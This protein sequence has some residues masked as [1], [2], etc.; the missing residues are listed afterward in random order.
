MTN[1]TYPRG[2]TAPLA[3]G[4]KKSSLDGL[5]ILHVLDHSLPIH[6]GYSFRSAAL[7]REQRRRGWQTFHLTTTK[8]TESGPSPE[9]VDEFQFER[10]PE[11]PKLI[12]KIPAVHET[13]IICSVAQRITQIAHEIRP[14]ILHAHSPALN[15][16]ACLKAARHLRLPV[17]YEIRGFWEDAAVSHGT[18]REGGLR[19][20]ATHALESHVLKKCNAIATICDGLRSDL[21]ARG[22]PL[23]LITVIPN[24]V[25]IDEFPFKDE[26]E[27]QIKTALDLQG[28]QTIGFVGSFYE[29]EGLDL[30]LSAVAQV[31]TRDPNLILLLVGGGP[32]ETALKAQASRLGI[33][34]SVRFV[35]RV[36]HN[37]IQQYYRAIDINVYPRHPMRLTHTVTPLKPLEAMAQGCIVLASDVGGHRELIHHNDTGYLFRAGDVEACERAIIGAFR[38]RA[39][40]QRIRIHA[41][42]YVERERT[43]ASS[44]AGYEHLYRVALATPRKH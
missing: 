29:Y 12:R 31:L 19:Y 27:E 33:E 37:L 39:D 7:F 21:V 25:D 20:R 40:W 43:W 9:L 38:N 16:L 32:A 42:R 36:P 1:L 5:R 26:P 14:D 4:R 15:A 18:A 41:R 24:G 28:R 10:T 23:D 35:G 8:H 13:A 2:A 44:A 11:L 6:S 17:V 34:S 22:L 30:L 3:A